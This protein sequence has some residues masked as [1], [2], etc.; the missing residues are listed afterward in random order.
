MTKRDRQKLHAKKRLLERY[1]IAGDNLFFGECLRQINDGEAKLLE[2]QS[3]RVWL[4]K[5]VVD[6]LVVYAIFDAKRQTIVTFLT[7]EMALNLKN[8]P[9]K[10]Y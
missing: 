6:D 5:V 1:G 4:Y 10:N 2:R 8:I 9:E 7:E 3:N